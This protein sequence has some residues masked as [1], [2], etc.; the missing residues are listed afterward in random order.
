MRNQMK[1]GG[2][3]FICA[4][5][6]FIMPAILG[7]QDEGEVVITSQKLAE[8]IYMMSGQGGNMGVLI[9]GDG[10]FL[11]DH[12]LEAYNPKIRE[13]I[14]SIGGGQVKFLMNTHYHRDHTSGNELMRQ[15]GSVIVAHQNVRKTLS[16]GWSISYFEI[17]HPPLSEDWLPQLTFTDSL[18]FYLNG[19]EIEIFHVGPA[20]TDGDAV[21]HFK[22]ANVVHVGDVFFN[23]LYPFIDL[24][25]GGTFDGLINAIDK[26]IVRINEDTKI[27]PGHGPASNFAEFMAYRDMLAAIVERVKKMID[28]GK[29][30]EDIIAARPSAEY[31]EANAGFI[32]ADDL[33]KFVY[34]D[35]S[36]KR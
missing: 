11:I 8:N 6:L 24:E 21:V 34:E 33:V 28:D 2:K 14:N 36:N 9:G 27:I 12:Q 15:S 10:T 7:A 16:S 23:D 13:V 29:K 26:I 20:H 35:L 3:L 25:N 31:D 1:F 19:E 18:S 32:P 5:L 17:N 30:L 22:K 4:G